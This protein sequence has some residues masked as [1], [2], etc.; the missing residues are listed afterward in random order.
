MRTRIARCIAL[1]SNGWM[2]KFS[3]DLDFF[4]ET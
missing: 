3:F 1:R 2:V 4:L